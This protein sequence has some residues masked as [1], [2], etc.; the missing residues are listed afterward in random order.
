[1]NK[2]EKDWIKKNLKQIFITD[3]IEDNDMQTEHALDFLA[4]LAEYVGQPI[5][6]DTNE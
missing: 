1:M 3:I 5:V 4:A 2:K 6:E